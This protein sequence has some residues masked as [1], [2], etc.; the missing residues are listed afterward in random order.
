MDINRILARR[1][2]VQSR[3]Y[4]VI[5]TIKPQNVFER[6]VFQQWLERQGADI[7][8]TKCQTNCLLKNEHYL[9][10]H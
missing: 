1:V 9:L 4:S 3:Q 7:T 6:R 10:I 8:V 5:H 2:N